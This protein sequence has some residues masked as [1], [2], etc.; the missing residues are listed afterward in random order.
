MARAGTDRFRLLLRRYP[1]QSLTRLHTRL[2]TRPTYSPSKEFRLHSLNHLHEFIL[3]LLIPFREL[4]LDS[5]LRAFGLRALRRSRLTSSRVL[6]FDALPHPGFVPYLILGLWFY[7]TYLLRY[8]T[9]QHILSPCAGF[10][11]PKIPFISFFLSPCDLPVS[12][13]LATSVVQSP[14]TG[15]PSA[16]IH[17]HEF[18]PKSLTHSQEIRLDS[19][20]PPKDTD[21]THFSLS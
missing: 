13:C 6:W 8:N 7:I 15:W 11:P 10:N 2:H 4:R 3:K 20:F 21:S 9:T 14:L 19:S 18:R 1:H 17:F 12:C 16:L 5:R